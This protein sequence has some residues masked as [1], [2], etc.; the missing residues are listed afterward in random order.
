MIIKII[1]IESRAKKLKS[2]F[3]L[4]Q[5]QYQQPKAQPRPKKPVFKAQEEEESPE[6]YDVSTCKHNLEFAA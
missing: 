2:L 6:D 1:S 3:Q 4:S 5:I